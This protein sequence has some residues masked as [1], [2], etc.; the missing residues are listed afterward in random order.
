MYHSFFRPFL[1]P[2]SLTSFLPLL[3]SHPP[4]LPL[5]SGLQTQTC[6]GT[7]GFWGSKTTL[8]PSLFPSQDLSEKQAELDK[9]VAKSQSLAEEVGTSELRQE[10]WRLHQQFSEITAR[11]DEWRQKEKET[12]KVHCTHTCTYVYMYYT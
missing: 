4:S 11:R 6:G 12:P 3:A 5:V 10:S 7:F 9:L 1:P 2:L 8:F